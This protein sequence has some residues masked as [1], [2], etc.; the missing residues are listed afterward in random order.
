M[1]G[2]GLQRWRACAAGASASLMGV[3]RT[4]VAARRWE[5]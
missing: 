3:G 1:M 4:K 2:R 5:E